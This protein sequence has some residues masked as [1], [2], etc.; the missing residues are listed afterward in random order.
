MSDELSP[1]EEHPSSGIF[2]SDSSYRELH[3]KLSELP[4]NN[5]LHAAFSDVPPDHTVAQAL[6]T[7]QDV[8]KHTTFANIAMS[9]TLW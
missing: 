5:P 6:Q 2:P 7:L 4:P 3:V 1:I 8:S 9:L